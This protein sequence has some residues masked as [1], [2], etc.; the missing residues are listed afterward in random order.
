MSDGFTVILDVGGYTE[1]WDNVRVPLSE[2]VPFFDAA[3]VARDVS[4]ALTPRVLDMPAI[5]ADGHDPS[6]ALLRVYDGEDLIFA[7]RATGSVRWGRRG[8]PIRLTATESPWDDGAKIPA[9]WIQRVTVIDEAVQSAVQDANRGGIPMSAWGY[10][11]REDLRGD[12]RSPPLVSALGYDLYADK[13]IGRVGPIVFGAPGYQDGESW[14]ATP[15]YW[16]DTTEGV[17]QL[18]IARHRVTA[19][20][21]TIYGPCYDGEIRGKVAD[22]AHIRTLEGVEVAVAEIDGLLGRGPR[23]V[24]EITNDAAGTYTVAGNLEFRDWTNT[25]TV[26]VPFSLVWLGGTTTSTLNSF[27]AAME[28]AGLVEPWASWS[29]EL[30]GLTTIIFTVDIQLWRGSTGVPNDIL[31]T[32]QTAVGGASA[33][34]TPIPV[35]N[36]G[37][38]VV[39][40]TDFRPDLT[41]EWSVAWTGGEALPGGAGD[42]IR[43]VLDQTQ[44]RVD[45]AHLDSWRRVLN[46]YTLAGCID[47]EVVAAQWLA[48]QLA[49]LPIGWTQGRDGLRLWVYDPEAPPVATID[50]DLG[51]DVLGDAGTTEERPVA[52]VRI[53][54]RVGEDRAGGRLQTRQQTIWSDLARGGEI[55]EIETDLCDETASAERAAA[56]RQRAQYAR[57]LVIRG[58][59]D[60]SVWGWLR[61]GD[62]VDVRAPSRGVRGRGIVVEVADDGGPRIEVELLAWRDG[63]IAGSVFEVQPIVVPPPEYSSFL[64][65]NYTTYTRHYAAPV[66]VQSGSDWVSIY[67]RTGVAGVAVFES[68]GAT[69]VG[70]DTGY[71]PGAATEIAVLSAIDYLEGWLHDPT[72]VFPDPPVAGPYG[73]ADGGWAVAKQPLYDARTTLQNLAMVLQGGRGTGGSPV[74]AMVLR[75]STTPG[76]LELVS[77]DGATIQTVQTW[78]GLDTRI[79]SGTGSKASW[80]CAGVHWSAYDSPQ[81]WR[82]VIFVD[83]DDGVGPQRLLDDSF[84]EVISDLSAAASVTQL[85]YIGGSAPGATFASCCV[86]LGTANISAFEQDLLAS[87][88]EVDASIL[89]LP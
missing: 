34:V 57:H 67:N 26:L 18:Q 60:R 89:E 1:R 45:R 61:A 53:S 66:G 44:I 46:T 43:Y 49:W 24:I 7:G 31:V 83:F 15:A 39:Q 3:P 21:V 28:L 10:Y 79:G 27:Q 69:P 36:T 63:E 13:A 37:A 47:E 78:T 2:R 84:T 25:S 48:A 52:Q 12:P 9:S 86:A 64:I 58:T 35:S 68:T 72:S 65:A 5:V 76:G 74:T 32:T 51:L 71:A 16:I 14:G 17:E 20:T 19:S 88:Y 6:D 40:P 22:V 73:M 70:V 80:I 30:V 38:D 50:E 81:A 82:V 4:I 77:W 87:M 23:M 8:S 55:V 33:M 29:Y 42:V 62:P 11:E 56:F 75:T 59:L 41:A 85:R 54:Y